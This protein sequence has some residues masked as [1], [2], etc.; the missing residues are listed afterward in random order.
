MGIHNLTDRTIKAA[1]TACTLRDGGGLELRVKNENSKSWVLRK[2]V[3]GL[4]KEYGLG[5]LVDVPLKVARDKAE[6]YRQLIDQGVDPKIYLNGLAKAR[7]V[8][9][10]TFREAA[11]RYIS[12]HEAEW[13]NEKHRKQWRSTIDTYANPII[14]SIPV[15]QLT[16]DHILEILKPIWIDKTETATRIRERIEKIIGAGAAMGIPMT[17][18]PATWKGNLEFRL[19]K[20]SKVKNETHFPAMPHQMLPDFWLELRD[21]NTD[22]S[23]ALQL[24]ILTAARTSEILLAQRSEIDLTNNIWTIPAE[25]V[26]TKTEHVIPITAHMKSIIERQI[27]KYSSDLLF[28]GSRYGKPLSNMTCLKV[29]K[30]L[31][32]TTLDDKES[33]GHFVPHGFRSTFSTW[34]FENGNHGFEVIESCLGHN[35]GNSVHRAYQRSTLLDRRRMLLKD[36]NDFVT[37]TSNE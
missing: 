18:N 25:R 22:G 20:P 8:K 10:I 13:T 1:K 15:A 31:G 28:P 7:K 5:S 32:Y 24:I 30:D 21:K 27:Q 2:T 33:K 35:V 19:A 11:D 9:D 29:M 23:R 37:G 14:G 16:A 26:K 4:R 6:Q 3:N 17:S 12:E 34:A 36:W